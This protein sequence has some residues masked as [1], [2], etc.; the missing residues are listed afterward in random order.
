MERGVTAHVVPVG[1]RNEDGRQYRQAG[2][3]RSQGLEGSF[4]GFRPRTGINTDQLS[5]IVGN[6]EIV[7]GELETRERIYAAR[8]DLGDAPR[9]KSVPGCDLFRKRRDQRNRPV[10]VPVA[11]L[12]QIVLCLDLFSV[13]EGQLSKI[14]ENFSQPP[15]VWRL[16]SVRH[17]PGQLVLRRLLL[18]EEA[19][20]LSM[21]DAGNPVHH[22]Q[23]PSGKL[24]GLFQYS[25]R[26]FDVAD[27]V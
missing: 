16:V 15:C 19:W 2:R 21:D 25:D 24:L 10:K 12:P 27:S 6:H 26:L 22:E 3:V 18:M 17:A 4:G 8:H 20:K 9:R 5:S 23:V 13:Y 11:T 14:V 7:F 1:V